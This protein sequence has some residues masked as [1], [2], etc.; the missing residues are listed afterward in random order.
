MG[1]SPSPTVTVPRTPRI[2]RTRRWLHRARQRIWS[3][4]SGSPLPDVPE[5][6]AR[7]AEIFGVPPALP[8]IALDAE[9]QLS[10]LLDF[11][12]LVREFPYDEDQPDGLRYRLDN[13]W[14]G[15]GDAVA[16]YCWLRTLRPRRYVEIG[17]GWSSA[18]VLDVN[19]RFLGGQMRCTFV[20]PDPGR[21]LALIGDSGAGAV[22]VLA[23]PLYA[24]PVSLFG[25]LGPGD[26]LFIDS[27]HI[28]RVGSDVNQ[29]FLD[30]V[31]R[32]P[33]GVFVHVHDTP[34]PFEYPSDWVYQGRAWNETY[35][36]RALLTGNMGL[37]IRWFNSY[38]AQLHRTAVGDALPPWNLNPGGSI[39]LDTVPTRS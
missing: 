9:I 39:W 37:R 4:Q 26:V 31:P 28:S 22:E 7:A 12:E 20:D 5:V 29:L 27:S 3:E 30:V 2:R 23:C 15:A 25:E 16:L 19:E 21:L 8:D 36:L 11:A 32:L 10:M 1:H 17:S 14:F 33:A 6:S 18:L 13:P 35:L 34:Y 24:A 38:L